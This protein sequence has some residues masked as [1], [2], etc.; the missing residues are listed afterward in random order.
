MCVLFLLGLTSRQHYFSY[1]AIVED[2]ARDAFLKKIGYEILRIR[3]KD[4]MRFPDSIKQ[5]IERLV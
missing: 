3:A 1:E 2:D 4:L 5:I